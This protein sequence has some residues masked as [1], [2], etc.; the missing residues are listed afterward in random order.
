MPNKEGRMHMSSSEKKRYLYMGGKPV[1]VSRE[2]YDEYRRSKREER[3][4]TKDLK[5]EAMSV[6][7][8][9]ETVK[10]IPSRE[11]S[12]ERLL[13]QD[14]QFAIPGEMLEDKV[15]R[16]ILLEKALNTLTSEEQELIRELYYLDK[17]ERQV[18][19]ALHMA[20]ST[21][22][23]QRNQILGKLRRLLDENS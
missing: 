12:Y 18:S 3:Y 23:Y 16:G 14:K 8:E 13:E 2:V 15:I 17:T 4:F 10:F 6:D 11:D 21:L 22:H 20:K 1:E 7:Q 5:R 19:E 9:N